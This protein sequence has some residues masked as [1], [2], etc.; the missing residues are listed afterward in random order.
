MEA[1]YNIIGVGYDLT[2]KADPYIVRHLLYFLKPEPGKKYLDIGCGTGNYTIALAE[3][4]IA[5][6]GIEPSEEMLKEARRRSD[7]VTWKQGKNVK[8]PS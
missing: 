3:E 8:N 4:G 5:F 1:I 6:T 2:R 7:K